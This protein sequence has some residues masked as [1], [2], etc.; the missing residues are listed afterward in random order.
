MVHMYGIFLEHVDVIGVFCVFVLVL[1]ASNTK[2]LFRS[3]PE[4]FGYR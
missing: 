4:L 1:E 3:K 2:T